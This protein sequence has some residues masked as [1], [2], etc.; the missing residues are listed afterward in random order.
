[1]VFVCENNRYAISTASSYAIAGQSVAHRA[2]AYGI[3]GVTVDGQD[4]LAVRDAAEEAVNRARAGKGP[5]VLECLTYRFHG[6]T[7]GEE[8]LG[9]HYRDPAEIEQERQRD[10]IRLLAQHAPQWLTP[11]VTER[12]QAAA[13]ME[14]EQAVVFA[15]Q[16][17]EPDP[18]SMFAHVWVED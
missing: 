9:W 15:E 17:P 8:G 6:H 13:R 7:E 14:V 2:Q 11:E 5:E 3:S 12:I 4:V 18:S 16:S 1:M 10:P